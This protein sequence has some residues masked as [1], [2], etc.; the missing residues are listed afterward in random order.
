MEHCRIF[1]SYKNDHNELEF[2]DSDILSLQKPIKHS[3]YQ[4]NL[5][6]S[7]RRLKRLKY[8]RNDCFNENFWTCSSLSDLFNWP[9]DESNSMCLNLE[10]KLQILVKSLNFEIE[11]SE[12]KDSIAV[13]ISRLDAK[14]LLNL[15]TYLS[16][17]YFD[18]ICL[19]AKQ[20]LTKKI[21]KLKNLLRTV[22]KFRIVRSRIRNYQ[23]ALKIINGD[24]IDEEEAFE[25]HIPLQM[26]Y[27]SL[28]NF[29]HV[30]KRKANIHFSD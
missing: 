29:S 7:I 21:N 22:M 25:V 27:L 24:S 4:F 5:E 12:I 23:R 11:K 8:Q 14:S 19:S 16:L 3:F 1:I 9:E 20:I 10:E 2:C 30:K 28:I 18:A 26:S 17:Y 13:K 6:N 15:V